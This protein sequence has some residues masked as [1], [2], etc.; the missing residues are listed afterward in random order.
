MSR[1][2]QIFDNPVTRERAVILTDPDEHPDGVLVA[3]LFVRPGGRVAV[4]HWHPA[5]RE[6]FHVIA[7]QV[8]FLIG[9]SRRTL[10]PGDAAEIPPGTLHDWWQVGADE[11]QVIVEVA[12]GGRFV[13]MVGT[14]FGLARDGLVDRRGIPRP[15]QLAVTA[16][17]YRD[18]MVIAS[19][20]PWA[21]RIL[22][23]LL[24][25]IGRL[26]GLRPGYPKYFHSSVVTT[27]AP[28]ALAMLSADG[29]LRTAAPVVS[30]TA[31]PASRSSP[32]LC[33]NGTH[34]EAPRVLHAALASAT[35]FD[36][37]RD[38]ST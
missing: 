31:P 25:P 8:G 6:R 4:A 2:G 35:S 37:S 24:A 36:S 3:H 22:F 30:H 38:M 23:A 17:H 32:Y 27:P 12:P 33:V 15:L 19:P 21:Q 20:P 11:A 14:T 28:E 29:R 7:G 5:C 26:F 1:R 34:G 9:Q 10:G 13:E 18:V 16:R